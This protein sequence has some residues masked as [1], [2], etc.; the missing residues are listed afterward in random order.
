M[1]IGS[2][3]DLFF[4][5]HHADRAQ[6]LLQGVGES[7]VIQP[8]SLREFHKLSIG[9]RDLASIAQLQD[10]LACLVAEFTAQSF[11]EKLPDHLQIS[12]SEFPLVH[13][14]SHLSLLEHYDYSILGIAE[15]ALPSTKTHTINGFVFRTEGE[16]LSLEI[17]AQAL[18]RSPPY[19]CESS[20]N[21]AGVT[22]VCVFD[23]RHFPSEKERHMKRV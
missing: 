23:V 15:L 17:P 12:C 11:H 8:I 7:L 19:S 16:R 6:L 14:L 5:Q 2:L 13:Y 1:C 21:H 18:M 10:G 20:C 3:S 22:G 9:W 4:E